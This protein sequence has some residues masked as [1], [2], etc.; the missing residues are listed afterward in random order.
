MNNRQESLEDPGPIV[1]HCSAGI[2]RTGTFIVIDL[3]ID[4]VE[5]RF[6]SFLRILKFNFDSF[7]TYDRHGTFSR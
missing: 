2:G 5:L 4:Q 6:N 1:V 7:C 3:I